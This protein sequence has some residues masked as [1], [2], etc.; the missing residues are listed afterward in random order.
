MVVVGNG[1]AGFSAAKRLAGV[2][3]GV[4]VALID[5]QPTP[6]YTKIRLP[7]Y[8]SGGVAEEKL[9]MATREEY[10]R[11]GIESFLGETVGRID[12]DG[13]SLLTE[14]GK[15]LRYD[16]LVL[17]TGARAAVPNV[18]GLGGDGVYTLRTLPD[19]RAIIER[20]KKAD[21]A[22]VIGGGLLGL[23][24][25]Y[26]M[27]CRGLDVTVVEYFPR[28]LPKNLSS[29]ESDILFDKMRSV[30][31]RLC[32][33]ATTTSVVRD[34]GSLILRTAKGDSIRT[35]MILVSAGIQPEVSLA[36]DVGLKVG[37]GIVVDGRLRSSADGVHAVGDCAE[38]NGVI[39]GLWVAAKEQGEAVA[40]II[41]GK[42]QSYSPTI[43]APILKVLNIS[44]KDIK[45]EAAARS[46][47][48]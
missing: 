30:G 22:V 16:S 45:A 11:L 24:A 15:E 13:R 18:E 14:S 20:L 2:G 40:D 25:A 19:A 23:E 27:K 12:V 47:A 6:L 32:L 33:G 28:L 29:A 31:L 36:K 41:L 9:F 34:S 37:R 10:D 26:A 39:Q 7:E 48:G 8:L 3:A 43:F 4:S 5:S 21:S 1:A 42:R 17:A 38:I 44:I 46:K 35:S